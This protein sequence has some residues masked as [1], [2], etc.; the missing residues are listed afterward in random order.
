[1]ESS[2]K[3]KK[4]EEEAIY[5]RV[6]QTFCRLACARVLSESAMCVKETSAPRAR[7]IRY[8]TSTRQ[9]SCSSCWKE[10]RNISKKRREYERNARTRRAQFVAHVYQ[11]SLSVRIF[12]NDGLFA[13]TD[14][15]FD[16]VAIVC[17]VKR[18]PRWKIY[19]L[20]DDGQV[21]TIKIR[22]YF[23]IVSIRFLPN[24]LLVIWRRIVYFRFTIV[25]VLKWLTISS[26]YSRKNIV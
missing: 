6:H 15:E 25:Q 13:K 26:S 3:K 16:R 9:T 12:T 17:N 11:F 1:M 20:V 14:V 22:F 4:K 5:S 19:F 23:N 21:C 10:K 7:W 18:T 8:N 24:F 2:Q